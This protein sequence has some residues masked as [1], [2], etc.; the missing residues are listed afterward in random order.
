[1]ALLAVVPQ[2]S[3]WGGV[4]GWGGGWGWADAGAYIGDYMGEY[5]Q[6]RL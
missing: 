6:F 5:W 2:E 3:S 1:M 4:G